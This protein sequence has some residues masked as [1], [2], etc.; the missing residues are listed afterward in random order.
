MSRKD[1]VKD[2]TEKIK[3]LEEAK[4]AGKKLT[5]D[6]VGKVAGGLN[7][8]PEG[9]ELPEGVMLPEGYEIVDGKLICVKK[10]DPSSVATAVPYKLH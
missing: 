2:K 7:K 8:L 5:D 6:E 1:G 4:A 3:S 9:F 10:P